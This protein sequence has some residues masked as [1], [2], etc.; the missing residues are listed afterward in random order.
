MRKTTILDLGA[1]KSEGRKI[2]MI[3]AYDALFSRIFDGTDVDVILVGDSLGQV[4]LGY[5]DTL[6]VTMED[7]I[8]H[9]AA[10]ARGR[11]RSLLVADMP[12]LS[13]Q[14]GIPDAIRNAGLLL[15]AGAEGVKLEGGRNME[16]TIRA[17]AACDIPV[18]GHIGLT[19]QS[20]HRMGGYRVQGKTGPQR[21]RLLDDAMAVQEAGAF[22]MVL[23]GIPSALAAEITGALSIPTI[24]IGAGPACDGQVLVMQDLLGLFDEFQPKFVKRFGELR[25][26]VE[27]AVGAFARAVRDGS[28]PDEEHSF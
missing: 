3:T 13:Y 18:M 1:M 25:K 5:P 8:R 17:I 4:V 10:A 6:N 27:D 22:S 15:Q 7:M 2:V 12:F 14:T 21:E 9:T 24:G 19:P 16:A 28:F 23:E 11:K 26:P 20:V